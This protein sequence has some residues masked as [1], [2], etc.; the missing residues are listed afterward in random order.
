[1]SLSSI[2]SSYSC[3]QSSSN[4]QTSGHRNQHKNEMDA[5]GEALQSGD[6][7][8]AQQAFSQMQQ[9]AP[10]G[11]QRSGNSGDAVITDISALG[12]ALAAS[13][14]SSAQSAFSTLQSDFENAPPPPPSANNGGVDFESL[15]EQLSSA[16]ESGDLTSAQDTFSSLQ[17]DIENAP[18]PPPPGGPGGPGGAGGN[19]Q[20]AQAFDDLSTALK[21]GDLDAAQTAFETLQSLAP[22]N[23]DS[24]SS[25]A[26][27]TSG[28]D[29]ISTDMAALQE[30]LQNGDLDSAQSLFETLLADLQTNAPRHPGMHNYAQNDTSTTTSNSVS[31]SA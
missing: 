8:A 25:T 21:N 23:Q 19:D 13:D 11:A 22:D 9:H 2:S 1:M 14:L 3:Y 17:D 28:S 4:Y 31:T 7:S 18:P 20:V 5:L 10:D 15:M 30:A 26:N 24:S 16:L 29:T 12:Q 6:L 27:A